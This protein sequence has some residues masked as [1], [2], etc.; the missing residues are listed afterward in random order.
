[1]L[2]VQIRQSP[3]RSKSADHLKLENELIHLK[4]GGLPNP[5]DEVRES[6]SK[7]NSNSLASC[8]SRK[9]ECA[10]RKSMKVQVSVCWFSQNSA[11]HGYCLTG[12]VIGISN[13]IECHDQT[14]IISAFFYVDISL[15]GKAA[16]C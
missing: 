12:S 10:Q 14:S 3:P 13:G 6:T 7:C 2:S 5:Q 8:E 16:V 1:M 11:H 9:E 15:I 4:Y